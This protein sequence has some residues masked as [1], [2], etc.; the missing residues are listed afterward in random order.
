MDDDGIL[1]PEHL[2]EAIHRYS[3]APGCSFRHLHQVN[4]VDDFINEVFGV[5]LTMAQVNRLCVGLIWERVGADQ[6]LT[7]TEG[8]ER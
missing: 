1:A 7:L 5:R 4:D 2:R 8:G 6:V 3:L